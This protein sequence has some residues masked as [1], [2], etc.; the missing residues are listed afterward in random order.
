MPSHT[1]QALPIPHVRE[2]VIRVQLQGSPV[3]AFSA[4]KVPVVIFQAGRQGGVGPR[5]RSVKF[6]GAQ[7][8]ALPLGAS[9]CRRG[10]APEPQQVVGFGEAD[11]GL[12]DTWVLVESL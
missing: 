5:I 6:K 7:S 8:G 1:R 11:P 12:G 4:R 10:M 3:G 9:T 2:G